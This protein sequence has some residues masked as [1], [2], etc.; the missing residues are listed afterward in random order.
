MSVRALPLI[1]LL[2]LLAGCAKQADLP[3][4]VIAASSHEEFTRFRSELGTR[5]PADRL[6]DFDTATR[7]LQLDAMNREIATADA[8]EADMLR[9]AHGKTVHAVTVLG[10]GARKARFLRE[11]AEIRAMLERDLALQ[12]K[13]AA[14][15]TPE[16]VTRRIGSEREVLA[17]LERNLADTEH[18]LAELQSIPGNRAG[19]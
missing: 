17:Q 18:H 11:I 5:F 1:L 2:G 19:N 6:R 8:R 15:G 7:E 4:T 12:A 14:T 10:W 3:D 9:A 13:S 16:S